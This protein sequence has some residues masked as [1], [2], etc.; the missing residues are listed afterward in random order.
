MTHPNIELVQDIYAA[1]GRGDIAFILDA[2]A[3]DITWGLVG[4][5]EDIPMAG[6]R[7][8]K[9]GVTDFFKSL[10]ETQQITAFSPRS[11]AANDDTVFVL[12]H[13]AWIMNS[14]GTTG[15]N[16][17]VHVFGI[18]A[19]KVTSYRGFQDTALLSKAH[20]APARKAG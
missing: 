13:A 10:K 1:F 11:F 3:P 12:G 4:N 16:P 20:H 6:I 14:N 19:G 18:K 17:G 9:A 5:A 15:E 8:G 7:S 2:V